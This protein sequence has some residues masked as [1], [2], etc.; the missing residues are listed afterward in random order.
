MRHARRVVRKSIQAGRALAWLILARLALHW[1]S[2]AAIR[3]ALDRL[4]RRRAAA[5]MTAIECEQALR[6]ASRVLNDATC[7]ARAIAAACLLRR[8]DH[9]ATLVIG[10]R[11]DAGRGLQ[12][13]AWLES[14]GRTITGAAGSHDHRILLRDTI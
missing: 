4:P 12:A 8:E 14:G 5:P 10:V 7:L 2:Y 13:H 3:R 9:D 6:R 11:F 1:W